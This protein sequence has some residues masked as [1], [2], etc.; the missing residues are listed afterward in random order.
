MSLL[1][2]LFGIPRNFNEVIERATSK[3]IIPN[4]FV[5]RVVLSLDT[6]SASIHDDTYKVK[7]KS[8]IWEITTSNIF[9]KG[10]G[11]Y[12]PR[13]KGDEENRK[14]ILETHGH[15]VADYLSSKGIV[16]TVNG[17]FYNL[18]EKQLPITSP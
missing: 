12:D 4:V 14:L 17:E 6:S 1:Y 3:N 18:L 2:K 16:V 13:A 5:R 8:G 9:V 7:I 10:Y 11:F 15:R